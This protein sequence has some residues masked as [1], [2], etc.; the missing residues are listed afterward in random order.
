[1]LLVCERK[2][3]KKKR[4]NMQRVALSKQHEA[5]SFKNTVS[6]PRSTIHEARIK[7]KV[8]VS[9]VVFN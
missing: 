6:A 2:D 8:I 7:Q 3:E 9:V 5:R 4:K 1:M